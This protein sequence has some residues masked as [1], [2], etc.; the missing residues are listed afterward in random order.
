MDFGDPP[1]IYDSYIQMIAKEEG[2]TSKLDQP[3]GSM[4]NKYTNK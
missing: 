2:H 3:Q 1:D 4:L